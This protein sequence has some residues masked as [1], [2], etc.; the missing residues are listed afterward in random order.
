MFFNGGVMK[1]S[2]LLGAAGAAAR[3]LVL[4][5]APH[6]FKPFGEVVRLPATPMEQEPWRWLKKSCGRIR[7]HMW[8]SK[9]VPW[10]SKPRAALSCGTGCGATRALPPAAGLQRCAGQGLV[11]GHGWLCWTGQ[12]M[13]VG[14]SGLGVPLP[15]RC[16]QPCVHLTRWQSRCLQVAAVARPRG[17]SEGWEMADT[18]Q[19][20][21]AHKQGCFHPGARWRYGLRSSFDGKKDYFRKWS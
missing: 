1:T 19:G 7:W 11:L 13:P 14:C 5:G 6:P 9:L 4:Q 2:H 3:L 18:A 15:C 20:C 17:P 8:R 10:T 12:T 16:K 21:G